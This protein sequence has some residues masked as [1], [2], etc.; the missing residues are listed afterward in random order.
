MNASKNQG[1]ETLWGAE[2]DSLLRVAAVI[3]MLAAAV[4]W[5]GPA[6]LRVDIFDGDAAHHVW[7]LYRYADPGLYAGDVMVEY[8]R[9]SAPL[10]YRALYAA[11]APFVDVLWAT[12][13]LSA[14]VYLAGGWLAWKIGLAIEG[15]NAS[16]R[17]LLMT[18]AFVVVVFVSRES[19]GGTLPPLAFQRTFSLPL[20][21]LCLWA[22]IA[23]RYVWVGI[24][25]VGSALL[26]PVMLPVMGLAAGCV[27]LAD[28]VAQRRMPDRWQINAALAAGALGLALF[29]LP[30]AETLGPEFTFAE[31]VAMPEYGQDG[32]LQLFFGSFV[33]DLFR[34]HM[35]GL[36]WSPYVVLA[37]AV[38]LAFVWLRGRRQ[39]VPV[40]AWA[41]LGVGLGLW[42][43]MRLFPAQLMFGLYLPNRHARWSIAVF[44]IVV[45]GAAAYTAIE[46][47]VRM[48]RNRWPGAG[49]RRMPR[50]IA[51]AVP[52]L[53]T[54]TL[55]PYAYAQLRLPVDAD[56]EATYAFIA[57]LPKDTLVAAQP[58]LADYVPLRTRRSVLTSTETSMPWLRGYYAIVK[59]RVEASLR[60]A[61]ATDV[62]DLD[63]EMAPFGVDVFVTGPPVW[64]Q[65]HYLEPYDRELF[66]DLLARGRARGFA[67]RNPPADR[68]LF[69]SGDYYV[70]R[71][72]RPP[73]AAE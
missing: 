16:L 58:T 2:A 65:T 31:A 8:F 7:W 50:L 69:R 22:L 21:L 52:V 14:V 23:R 10:G 40:P 33:S 64:E 70:L 35:M 5:V 73:G 29:G 53:T 62:A 55:L 45:L 1:V 54:W 44:V 12:E 46:W 6:V 41:M 36:G 49:S 4:L 71:V 18:A 9:T 13:M 38:A 15:P 27:F 67:L 43:V 30:T 51:V 32:R 11:L 59:P 26:Y 3:A 72:D 37:V 57:T 61:Y 48:L 28:L 39:L 47:A 68:V 42:L 60:A 19:S 25:W 24:S 66:Q 34:G 17:A 63:K 20:M 56:L